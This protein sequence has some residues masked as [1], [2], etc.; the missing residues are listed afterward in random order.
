LLESSAGVRIEPHSRAAD[1]PPI[2]ALGRNCWQIARASK[3]SVL[4]DASDF[5]VRLEQTL[6][7]ARRSILII[8]WDFDGRIK[9]RPDRAGCPPLG[10]FLRTLV[11]ARPELEIRILVWSVAVVHAPSAPIPLL[12]GAPWQDHPR[13]SLRLDR[14]HPL[15][16]AHH[17]KIICIDDRLAFVGGIDLTVRRWDTCRHSVEDRHRIDPDGVAY[18]PVHDVQM[19]VDGAVARVLTN[20]ARQRWGQAASESLG[21]VKTGTRLWPAGL[22]P[23][24]LDVPVA[25]ARTVPQVGEEPAVHEVMTLTADMIAAARRSI[26]VETQYFTARFVRDAIEKSLIAANGPEIV[27]ILTRSSSGI[28]ERFVM[29]KNRDRLVRGLRRVDRHRRLRVFHAVVPGRFGPSSVHMHAKVLIIDDRMLRIGSSNLNNRSAGLDTECDLAIEAQDRAT[30]RAIARVRERL[31]AEHLD[32]TPEAVARAVGEQD[33]LIR[34]IEQLNR[35]PRGLRELPDSDVDGPTQPIA[36]T[37]LLD[38]PRPFEPRWLRR[39][40][41]RHDSKPA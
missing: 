17:Q 7:R 35:R 37:W 39:G 15:Y 6:R 21:P 8:G 5:Y 28:F 23:D 16:A 19:V 40:K 41:L 1:R 31:L 38:P 33:S 30:R 36:G 26:Y 11:E 34:G 3:V 20:L 24:F 32:V 29:G 22:E 12:L 4:I 13:I 18:N 2:L 27:V 14:Q 9:L 25:V 10:E